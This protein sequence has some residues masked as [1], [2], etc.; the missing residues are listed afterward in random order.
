MP[1][2]TPEEKPKTIKF[3]YIDKAITALKDL[4]TLTSSYL[5]REDIEGK[6][7]YAIDQIQVEIDDGGWDFTGLRVGTQERIF[8]IV[9][10]PKV[11]Q[12]DP[13]DFLSNTVGYLNERPENRAGLKQLAEIINEWFSEHPEA[14]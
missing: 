7:Q 9:K 11:L 10:T 12:I 13:D 2:I 4:E 3:K 5:P 6:V 1:T 8:E 14:V